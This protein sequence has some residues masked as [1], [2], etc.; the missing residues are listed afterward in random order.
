LQF[1]SRSDKFVLTLGVVIEDCCLSIW[2][3]T[4]EEPDSF[5]ASRLERFPPALVVE[6]VGWIFKGAPKSISLIFPDRLSTSKSF[7]PSF[8]ANIWSRVSRWCTSIGL[9]IFMLARLL[10]LSLPLV[11]GKLLLFHSLQL[12]SDA[13]LRRFLLKLCKLVLVL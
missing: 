1:V 10:F 7:F 11:H 5:S 12:G 4:I 3:G 2:R 9:A 8:E 13:E 6:A